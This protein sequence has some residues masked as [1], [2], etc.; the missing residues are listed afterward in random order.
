MRNELI[1]KRLLAEAGLTLAQAMEIAQGM[2]TADKNAKE[3]HAL[4]SSRVSPE[5]LHLSGKAKKKCYRCGRDHHVKDCTFRDTNCHKGGKRGH[6]ALVCKSGHCGHT[7]HVPPF[8]SHG[9]SHQRKNP[10]P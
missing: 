6:I 5:V 1:Q 10:L 2:E 4:R 9:T 7:R 8:I 3:L